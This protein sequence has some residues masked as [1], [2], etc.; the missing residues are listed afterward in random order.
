MSTSGANRNHCHRAGGR[1]ALVTAGLSAVF[2]LTACEEAAPVDKNVVRAIK[3]I[4]LSE[5]AAAQQRKISGLVKPIDY[6]NVS[7]EVSGQVV[8][9]EVDVG[10]RVETGDV[11]AVLDR[12]PYELAVFA[13]EAALGE[14]D[15]RF[16]DA[17]HNHRRQ[18]RLFNDGWVALAALDTTTANRNAAEQNVE[19]LRAKVSLAKRDLA[20]TSLV[21]AYSGSISKRAVEPFEEVRAG[22]MLFEL[23]SENGLEVALQAPNNLVSRIDAGNMVDVHFPSIGELMI[24]GEITEIGTHAST[25]NAFPVKVALLE[26][27]DA[28]RPG[29]TAEVAFS[30]DNGEQ[31]QGFMVPTSAIH[32]GEGSDHFVFAYD[33]ATSSLEKRKVELVELRD[34]AVQIDGESIDAGM[35]IATAG[36]PFFQDGLEVKLMQQAQR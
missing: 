25:A 36:V 31:A 21:A 32:S 18:E 33:E 12:E 30:Y 14:A 15:A 17:L 22:Q 35:I 20:K 16:Q 34:N 4:E 1:W 11:L 24:P 23:D 10:D 6:S 26:K 9:V 27:H 29:I 2:L 19:A 8:T 13:A 3:W 7:F 5:P 28:V